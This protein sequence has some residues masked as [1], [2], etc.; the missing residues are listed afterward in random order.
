[1]GV[2]LSQRGGTYDLSNDTPLQSV[3]KRSD[4]TPKDSVGGHIF[5]TDG[6]EHLVT[7]SSS[8]KKE[9]EDDGS[10][11]HMI[12]K[13]TDWD[14]HYSNPDQVLKHQI[15]AADADDTIPRNGGLAEGHTVL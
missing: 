9:E 5:R 12:Q 11:E 14:I 2:S 6:S 1:M 10:E 8:T 4:A 3:S 7:I 15:S 13:T